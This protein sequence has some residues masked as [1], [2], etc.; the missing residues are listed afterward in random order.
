MN[1]ISNDSSW[2][3]D[4]KTYTFYAIWGFIFEIITFVWIETVIVEEEVLK[5]IMSIIDYKKSIIDLISQIP[6]F[7]SLVDTINHTWYE[8]KTIS[9]SVVVKNQKLKTLISQN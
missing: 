8:L 4:S 9:F 5:S 3:G 1:D 2:L 6:I 7:A